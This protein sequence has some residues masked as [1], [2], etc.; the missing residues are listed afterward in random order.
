MLGTQSIECFRF[1]P[2][3]TIENERRHEKGKLEFRD[4]KDDAAAPVARDEKE[5]GNRRR[6]KDRGEQ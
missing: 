4:A 2:C 1:E 6:K 3:F 5:E